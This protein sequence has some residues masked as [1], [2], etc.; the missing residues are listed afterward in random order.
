VANTKSKDSGASNGVVPTSN[1]VAGLVLGSQDAT[2]LEFWVGVSE[3]SQI[4]LDDLV[5]VE[6]TTPPGQVIRFYGMVDVVRKRYEGAQFDSDAFR[7]AAGTLPVDVSYAA[8]V[9]VTRIA[10]E[11][12]VPP[13]PGDVVRIVRG[14]EFQRALYFDQMERSVAI[15]LTRTGEPVYANL[16]FLDGSRGAHASISGVSGV[17]TKTSYATFL[18]YSLFHSGALG[19][20]A[21]NS[22]ALIFNVKGEDLLWLDR[23][24]L[25]LNEDARAQYR[26]LGLPTGAFQSVGLYSPARRRSETPMPDTGGRQEGILPYL[27][28]MREFARNRLLRFAFAE[29]EDGRLLSAASNA[30]CPGSRLKVIRMTRRSR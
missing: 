28:T 6:T 15:G 17:A 27:W 13:H 14:E 26:R 3:G 10:P 25:M 21:I 30:R 11:I 19:A 4:E 2:P 20:D 5:T 24:N 22:K 7:A 16:E 29:A 1:A 9:Q 18:L 23:P 12:F 8:H